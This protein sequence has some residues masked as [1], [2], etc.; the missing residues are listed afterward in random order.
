MGCGGVWRGA[1]GRGV[2]GK[3]GECGG[4]DPT[5]ERQGASDKHWMRP[6]MNARCVEV[7]GYCVRCEKTQNVHLAHTTVWTL[8]YPTLT[9]RLDIRL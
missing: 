8:I 2:G 9:L 3:G 4:G 7:S 1:M 6:C 5:S